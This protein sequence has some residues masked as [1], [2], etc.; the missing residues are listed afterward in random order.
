MHEMSDT[1]GKSCVKKYRRMGSAKM[2]I[3]DEKV[4]SDGDRQSTVGWGSKRPYFASSS[5]CCN[6][7]CQSP[8]FESPAFVREIALCSLSPL[9]SSTRCSR[10]SP[11]FAPRPSVADRHYCGEQDEPGSSRQ[12]RLRNLD[13]SARR[14]AVNDTKAQCTLTAMF[15]PRLAVAAV[16]LAAGCAHLPACPAEGGPRWSEWSSPHFRV[17][18]DVEDDEDAE[19]LA[20]Q[21]EHFRAA[22]VA[23]AWRDEP[24]TGDPIEVAALRGWREADVFLPPRVEGLFYSYLGTGIVVAPTTNQV[25]RSKMLKH[26]VVHALMRQLDLDRNAPIWFKEGVAMYLA[27][28]S[29]EE[30]NDEVT[31][32]AVD[33]E[34]LS[35]VAYR[36]LT[37]WPELWSW[38]A[39]PIEQARHEATSCF[40]V[41][42]LFNYE[43]ERFQRFQIGLAS[44]SDA[45]LLWAQVFPD[46]ATPEAI[47]RT[48]DRYSEGSKYSKYK[49]QIPRPHFN[50]VTRSVPDGEVHALR[51]LLYA[52]ARRHNDEALARMRIELTEALRQEPLNLRARMVER[53][54]VGENVADMDTARALASKYPQAWQAWLVLAAAHGSRRE[55]KEFDEALEHARSLGFRGDAPIPTLPNVAAPY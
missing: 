24:D 36:G 31:F 10:R 54:F 18:T 53:L 26:E 3:A 46:M 50:F 12:D 37:P 27:M 41:H 17:L 29:Y 4:P 33:T 51:A 15:C 47:E 2:G 49:L 11:S 7:L 6:V 25:A 22:I 40:F 19:T 21:L 39:D 38:P 20:T 30:S 35:L 44:A 42:Y 55:G 8:A 16:T 43:R 52:T 32:G 45:K 23:A 1:S 28:T 14:W 5:S 13:G 48:L 9:A 34:A